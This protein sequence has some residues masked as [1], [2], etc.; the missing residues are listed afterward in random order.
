[1]GNVD[2]KKNNLIRLNK[3]LDETKKKHED[4]V[5]SDPF[6]RSLLG[7]LVGFGVAFLAPPAS[8]GF[9]WVVFGVISVVLVPCLYEI[10]KKSRERDIRSFEAKIESTKKQIRTLQDTED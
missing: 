9:N 4:E 2:F 5:K 3:I 1:M 8:G 6:L 10:N 7:I